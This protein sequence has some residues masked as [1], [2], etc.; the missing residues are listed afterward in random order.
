MRSADHGTFH[1]AFPL[2]LA[3]KR[4]CIRQFDR[5]EEYPLTEWAI[6]YIAAMI[7]L[8]MRPHTTWVQSQKVERKDR[9][10]LGEEMYRDLRILAEADTESK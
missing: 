3:G 1:D 10:R 2:L 5:Q 4:F 6:L 7:S 8:H 9:E